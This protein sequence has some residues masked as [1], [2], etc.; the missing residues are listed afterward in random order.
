MTSK[1]DS[2]ITCSSCQTVNDQAEVFC[3]ECGAPIAVAP[4]SNFENPGAPER[5]AET[6][7][8]KKRPR[9][10]VVTGFWF[11]CFPALVLNFLAAENIISNNRNFSTFLPF[12]LAVGL[13]VVLTIALYRVTKNYLKIPPAGNDEE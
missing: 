6:E 2:P 5:F 3:R 11:L 1:S 7:R 12:W 4:P 9:L 8:R 10:I 13:F